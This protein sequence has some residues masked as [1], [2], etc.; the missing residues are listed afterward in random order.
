LTCPTGTTGT[1]PNC[2]YEYDAAYTSPIT[3]NNNNTNTNTNTNNNNSSATNNN[4]NTA[5]VPSTQPT[6][7]YEYQPQTQSYIPS[8]NY[9]TGWNVGQ[10]YGYT[11]S[12]YRTSYITPTPTY[13]YPTNYVTPTVYATSYPEVSLN[14]IPY[15]GF[16]FGSFGDSIYYAMLAALGIAAAYLLAYY[17][18][19]GSLVRKLALKL[20]GVRGYNNLV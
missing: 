13:T 5:S 8:T 7:I 10:N 18:G 19:A 2:V 3:I 9:S 15:T 16:D 14:Q 17:A 1:Y 6:V 11:N 4:T 12:T 20:D